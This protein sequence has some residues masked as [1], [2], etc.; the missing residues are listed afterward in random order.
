MAKLQPRSIQQFGAIKNELID[1]KAQTTRRQRDIEKET[2][3]TLHHTDPFKT[4]AVNV[5]EDYPVSVKF[6]NVFYQKQVMYTARTVEMVYHNIFYVNA[7]TVSLVSHSM[8]ALGSYTLCML[9]K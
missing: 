4:M 7:C 5:E 1:A 2:T 9:L 6:W 3:M 8:T